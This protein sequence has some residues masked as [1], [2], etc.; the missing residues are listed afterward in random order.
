MKC[1]ARTGGHDNAEDFMPEEIA[2]EIDAGLGVE[3]ARADV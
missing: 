1:H 3:R 2:T